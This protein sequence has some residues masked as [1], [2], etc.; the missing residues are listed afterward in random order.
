[1]GSFM[2]DT[3]EQQLLH[4]DEIAGPGLLL[5]PVRVARVL[6]LSTAALRNWRKAD[7]P[8][9]W[10]SRCR[11]SSAASREL[12]VSSTRLRPGPS[13]GPALK[14]RGAKR[15]AGP[16]R[17]RLGGE[18][19]GAG[20]PPTIAVELREEDQNRGSRRHAPLAQRVSAVV[21]RKDR[22]RGRPQPRPTRAQTPAG[23]PSR[24]YS[25]E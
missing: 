25:P 14:G 19:V 21:S 5:A 12:V 2:A 18:G 13:A 6:D 7:P 22:R 17:A 10:R 9:G 3:L 16:G 20:Q 1:V 23:R 24:W 8:K 4:A 11:S 15:S